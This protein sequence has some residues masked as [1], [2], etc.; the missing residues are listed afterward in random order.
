[1]AITVSH[2]KHER[3]NFKHSV[4]H[5]ITCCNNKEILIRNNPDFDNYMRILKAC[6]E[7]HGF[8]LHDY[9]IMNNHVHL[10]IK[11]E[12]TEDISIIMH[13]INRW[14]ARWYNEHYERKGHFWEDRFYAE[15]IKDDM[16]LLAVMR[17]IGLNP[18]RAG[19]CND[20]T[21]WKFSGACHYLKG[22]SNELIDEPEVYTNLGKIPIERQQAYKNITAI[23]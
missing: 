15:L 18:V 5:V 14:Y 12:K 3:H 2:A 8:L 20:P 10:M 21:E 7:K 17:Y 22:D 6:K 11:L 13:S 16:Q 4:Q 19:L 1:M 23:N 9:V